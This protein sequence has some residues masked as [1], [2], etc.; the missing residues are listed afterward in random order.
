MAGLERKGKC[1]SCNGAVVGEKGSPAGVCVNC[2]AKVTGDHGE[3]TEA[4]RSAVRETLKEFG[5]E[6][7]KPATV[8]PGAEDQDDL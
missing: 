8:K 1:A 3:P 5:F 6:Q 2:G 4:I 7:K